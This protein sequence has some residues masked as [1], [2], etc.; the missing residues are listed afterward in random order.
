MYQF[1]DLPDG[2]YHVCFDKSTFPSGYGLTMAE[3]HG[4]NGTDSAADQQTGCTDPVT[5]GPWHRHEPD[6][7]RGPGQG[8]DRALRTGRDAGQDGSRA[9]R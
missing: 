5:L 1:T 4:G 8:A 9:C 3:V 2:G 6:A 7:R